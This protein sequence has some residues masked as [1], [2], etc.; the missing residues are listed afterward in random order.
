MTWI[1]YHEADG[2]SKETAHGRRK[3]SDR[4]EDSNSL[5]HLL[6]LVPEGHVIKHS[7]EKACFCH[8]YGKTD[9]HHLDTSVVLATAFPRCRLHVKS[10]YVN[11]HTFEV[12]SCGGGAGRYTPS[13][14]EDEHPL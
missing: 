9:T 11:T 2:I 6:G 12:L 14:D 8:A 5:R 10:R 3:L 13:E 1:S 4:I 7:W